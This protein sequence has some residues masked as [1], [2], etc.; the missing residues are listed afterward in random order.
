MKNL[1]LFVLI[2]AILTAGTATAAPTLNSY[3]T[4]TATLFMD[5]DGHDVNSSM[6]NYG[7]PFS[8]MPAAMTDA[9]ITE[10]F[11]RVAEDF[12]PFNINVT[13]DLSK[14]LAAP[15]SQRM[16]IV[17]TPTSAWYA[18]VAGIAY[19]TSFTW[20]DDTPAFV[21]SDRLG[22]NAKKVAEAVSH[23]SGH[24]LGL[25]HQSSYSTTCTLNSA[26]HT[27]AGTGETSWGPIMGNVAS[28]NATQWNYGPT[29]NGCSYLQDNL[30]VITTTNGFGYRP[31]D[32]A[33]L[34]TSASPITISNN[35]FNKAGVITTTADK[36]YFRFD[37]SQKGLFK[38]NAIP[39]STGAGN[40]GANL[41]VKI[42]LQD[43]KGKEIR[44]Y[45]ISDSLNA[46]IDTTL[47]AGTYYVIID[48]TGNI[49][50][51][52][53]YGSLGA[54]TIDGSYQP[55]TITTTSTTG[56]SN[57][58][59][60]MVTGI[61]VKNGNKLNWSNIDLKG[62]AAISVMVAT[63]EGDYKEIARPSLDDKTYVH[64]TTT[65]A[66]YS[67]M[68]KLIEKNGAVQF[69]NTVTITTKAGNAGIF[70]VIKQAQQPVIVNAAEAYEYQV[71][72]N[73]GHVI[74]AGKAAAGNQTIDVRNQPGGIY[75]LR[76]MN[77]TE[78]RTEKFMNR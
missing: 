70:K 75:N 56:T 17:V 51:G 5:F 8:C 23:E 13:T 66:A 40:S 55:T 63:A 37:L 29:P 3:P 72:D 42:I 39:F 57:T 32:Y 54:Y 15:I 44:T 60:L 12:R 16:R 65:P 4:A 67:Y 19:V 34:Y 53:D 10:A 36:D 30:S 78:Q 47:S 25:Y 14:F 11:N 52:N 38:L 71:V 2:A 74:L 31:D 49:N 35:V 26:Y 69:S 24:T 68:L 1:T 77:A 48:G 9:Q 20:G 46:R 27:G 76:L 28:R 18:G 33:D 41:D 58:T 62:T 59:T 21:F 22:N 73:F 43:A 50:A 7:T 61:Q 64:Q 6:W 45:D